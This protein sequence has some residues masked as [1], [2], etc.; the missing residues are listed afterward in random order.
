MVPSSDN[1]VHRMVR[2]RILHIDDDPH[3]LK[4]VRAFMKKDGVESIGMLNADQAIKMLGEY[5]IR[6]VLLDVD[7]PNADGLEILR[8]IKAWDAGIQVVMCTG[9]ITMRILVE[10]IQRGAE[11]VIFKPHATPKVLMESVS[12]AFAK[13]DRQMEAFAWLEKFAVHE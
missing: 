10:S 9:I 8:D 7:L 6:V 1:R 4:L 11:G 2:R 5:G 12:D 13:I 3:F